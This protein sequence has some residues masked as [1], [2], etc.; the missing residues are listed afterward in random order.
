[1]KLRQTAQ[2]QQQASMMQQLRTFWM[3]DYLC[4]VM[5]KSRDGQQHKG[6]RIIISSASEALRALLGSTFAESELIKKGEPVKIAASAS[7]VEAL[8][9]YVYGGEPEVATVDSM[10]LLRLASAY[11]LQFLAASIEAELLEDLQGS[12]ALQL[13]QQAHTFGFHRLERACEE[14]I[15]RDFQRTTDKPQFLELSAVQLGR[16][17]RREDLQVPREEL[18]FQALLKWHRSDPQERTPFLGLLMQ[19]VDLPALSMS[20][21]EQ[22]GL[23]A[24]SLGPDGADLCCDLDSALLLHRS[25]RV[26]PK[27]RCLC[28]W[29]P[30]LGADVTDLV[31]Q[32]QKVASFRGYADT[33]CLRQGT[34]YVNLRR[35]GQVASWAPGAADCKLVAGRGS[36]VQGFNEISHNF[37]IAVSPH[38]EV[39]VGDFD[40]NRLVSFQNGTGHVLLEISDSADMCYSPSGQLYILDD[41]GKRVRKLLDGG[42]SSVIESHLCPQEKFEGNYLFVSKEEVVYVSSDSRILRFAPGEQAPS[43]VVDRTEEEGVFCSFC[44]EQQQI[45]VVENDRK[46]I[47]TYFPGHQDGYVFLNDAA[48]GAHEEFEDLKVLDGWLY[49]LQYDDTTATSVVKRYPL[50][51]PNFRLKAFEAGR[52]A[53]KAFGRVRRLVLQTR[54][55]RSWSQLQQLLRKRRGEMDYTE[56]PR[57]RLHTKQGGSSEKALRSLRSCAC[58]GTPSLIQSS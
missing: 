56:V 14:H 1:M 16:I 32:G 55:K 35:T 9:D 22:V 2:M 41:G 5:F 43:A 47:S 36:G 38:G 28:F 7:V 50:Q 10:E 18:V 12:E 39:V 24:E 48:L 57:K 21:L 25:G 44:V 15:A 23:F 42:L 27:R 33:L 53:S 26:F 4:D 6:H 8:L 34:M 46:Q 30:Q 52:S 31:S 3:E 37:T 45:F 54:E 11:G 58:E 49:V 13:F 51:P 19:C 20:N 17:L 40:E 29:L